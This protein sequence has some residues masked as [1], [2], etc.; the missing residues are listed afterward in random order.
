MLG[1]TVSQHTRRVPKLLEQEMVGSTIDEKYQRST[2]FGTRPDG[3]WADHPSEGPVKDSKRVQLMTRFR[4]QSGRSRSSRPARRVFG[5]LGAT[6]N[7]VSEIG[8]WTS[9]WSEASRCFKGDVFSAGSVK[10][11]RRLDGS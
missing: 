6:S 2:R 4:P 8:Q 11:A 9:H 10:L 7:N 3:I 1:A 5:A